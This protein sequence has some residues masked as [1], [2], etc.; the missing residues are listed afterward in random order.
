M[1]LGLTI[2]LQKHLKIKSLSYGEPTD[3]F[4]CWELHIIRF[5]GKNTLVAVNANN[6]F[7]VLMAGMKAADWKSL[8]TRFEEAVTAGLFSEGYTKD[9]VDSYFDLAGESIFTK[10]HGR[11][12]VGGMNKAIDYLYYMPEPIEPDHLYQEFHCRFLNRDICSPIGFEGYGYPVEFLE[13]DMKRIG[14]IND[15]VNGKNSNIIEFRSRR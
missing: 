3:L 6:R 8:S 7:L 4:Y 15:I 2:P 12:P 11:K 5:Q 13:A 1:Q 14:I 9:Q 10:T